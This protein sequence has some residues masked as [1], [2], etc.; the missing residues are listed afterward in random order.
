MLPHATFAAEHSALYACPQCNGSKLPLCLLYACADCA[1]I[2]C[3]DCVTDEILSVYCPQ[4]LF[5]TPS[6]SIQPQQARYALMDLSNGAND[7]WCVQLWSRLL[8]MSDVFLRAQ[9]R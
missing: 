6:L 1:W 3:A 8:C 2:G 9:R 7:A 4:C 5:E